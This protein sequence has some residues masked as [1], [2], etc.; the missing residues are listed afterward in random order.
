MNKPIS[1]EALLRDRAKAI[2]TP[3][4]APVATRAGDELLVVLAG[5]ARYALPLARL[6]GVATLPRLTPLPGAPPFVAGL[7]HVQGRTLTVV[8]LGVL[9]GHPAQPARLGVLVDVGGETFAF[10]VAGVEGVRPAWP[11]G[12]DAVPEGVAAEARRLIE[13]VG[14]G[15]VCRVDLDRLID[16]LTNE[17]P[18]PRSEP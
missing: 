16:T 10:G 9:L 5:Q 4:R 7:A 3:A 18:G 14:P 1:E 8:S 13:A 15:G 6:A 2:A 17:G 12:E 11:A